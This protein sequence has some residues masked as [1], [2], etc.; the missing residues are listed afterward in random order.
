[1]T[2]ADY[3]SA[4]VR[5]YRRRLSLYAAV[6]A[7]VTA[8]TAG[9]FVYAGAALAFKIVRAEQAERL[10]G[11]PIVWILAAAA[12]LIAFA[13]ALSASF[14]SRKETARQLDA[15]GLQ[16]RAATMLALRNDPT[17]IALIRIGRAHV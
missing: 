13:A 5:P 11:D 9:A 16:E 7:L 8:V 14:P 6:R 1:M 17:E 2:W 12:A 10:Y 4:A 15:L 3:I